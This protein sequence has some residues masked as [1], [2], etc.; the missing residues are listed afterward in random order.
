MKNAKNDQK[1]KKAASILRTL[2]GKELATVSGGACRNCG[3]MISEPGLPTA[4]VK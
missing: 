4:T 1:N 2:D 3:I